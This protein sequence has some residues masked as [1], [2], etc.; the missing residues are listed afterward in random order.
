MRDPGMTRPWF[1]T[2][3]SAGRGRSAARLTLATL[4][5]LALLALGMHAWLPDTRPGAWSDLGVRLGPPV[6]DAASPEPSAPG[7][8]TRSPGEGP[9]L[10]GAP[11]LAIA[12]VLGLGLATAGLT[13]LY[14]RLTSRPSDP[15]RA[16][17]E[18]PGARRG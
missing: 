12:G 3:R 9:G 8:D 16:P 2:R 17:P 4:G 15:D 13:V 5:A 11:F 7:G 14:L 1:G 6:V 10:V 18:R